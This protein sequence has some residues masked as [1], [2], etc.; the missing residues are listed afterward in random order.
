MLLQ[1]EALFIMI[2]A[3]QAVIGADTAA[4]FIMEILIFGEEPFKPKCIFL[5]LLFLM[6]YLAIILTFLTRP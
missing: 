6:Y 4:V 2:A 1:A 5:T 3:I